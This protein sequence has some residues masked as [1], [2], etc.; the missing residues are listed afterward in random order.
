MKI[1]IID[2]EEDIRQIASMS[3]NILGGMDVV[4]ADGGED[5]IA[6]AAESQ[7]DAI[8]LDMMMPVLDGPGTLAKLREHPDT[9]QIPVIFLTARAMTTEVERLKTM[10]AAGI[11]TKPFDPTTLAKQVKD[12][13]GA[14]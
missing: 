4:E 12:I 5:G 7:P 9:K 1:L 6:K 14:S 11:L 8:L 10:G 13:L 2:D 3:L